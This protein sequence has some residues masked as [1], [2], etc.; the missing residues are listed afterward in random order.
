ML[1]SI[2]KILVYAEGL[3]EAEDR[4]TYLPVAP[5]TFSPE[6]APFF[7]SELALTANYVPERIDSAGRVIC[8]DAR[9]P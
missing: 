8:R 3:S 1:D 5:G 2:V 7:W 6:L 9:E 4:A